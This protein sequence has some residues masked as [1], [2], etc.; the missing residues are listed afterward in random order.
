MIDA[1]KPY[2]AYKDSGLPWL[3]KVPT[4][5]IAAPNRATF[6]EVKDR[7]VPDETML[8]VTIA[9]GVIRQADLL[10][11][12]SKKD[13]SNQDKS[14]YKLVRPGD[15]A[16]NKMRAW[17]G[18]CGVSD[19]RGIVSPAYIVVRPRQA[20]NSRYFH[21]LFRTPAFAKEAERW[22]YGIS[23]DQ[24]SLRPEEF[25][26]M[27]SCLPPMAEQ[28]SIVRFLDH[29]D[30]RIRRYINAKRRLIA[31]LNEQKQ[32]I[33]HRAVTR[34]LDPNVRLKPSGVEWLGD[35]PEHWQV[36]PLK[37]AFVSM[38]YGISES[39]VD[40]GSI[41]LLT[42][43]NIQFGRVIVPS[44]GGVPSVDP[45]LLLRTGDLL[46][47]RTN[48][49]EL[50]GKVGL[51]AGADSPVTFASYL[52]RLRPHPQHEPEYLNLVLNDS[53]VLSV[54]RR[55]AI[56]SLHQ[57][58]L[59][60][61]RYGRLQIAL[62]PLYEQ[63]AILQVQLANNSGLE[64]AIAAAQQELS[65]LLE[66]RTRLIADVVTGKLDVRDAATRLPEDAGNQS[67]LVDSDVLAVG[68]EATEDADID[69]VPEEAEV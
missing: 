67:T 68:D 37:R 11:N 29:A 61:T 20:Q 69:A 19:H 24:W 64:K 52:V 5:W 22:S 63:Q 58:N 57:S 21:Y 18:A 45:S 36:F 54:A 31:L 56:P 6:N 4:H 9:Q 10:A 17:Q 46:F 26:Q 32:A 27:Y 59:N 48:S 42:M 66:Y 16:Y 65:L 49:P 55:E 60:P 53:S 15:L 13:S 14:K 25:K 28:S 62:P 39:S 23:S 47:N 3:G 12:S 33:I 35:V 51:F 8:S 30:R 40:T 2:P 44:A 41:R 43:G 38:E 7:G 50:V 34:G 1:L